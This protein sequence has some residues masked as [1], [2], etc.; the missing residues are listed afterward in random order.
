MDPKGVRLLLGLL[1]LW[2]L[3]IDL[4]LMIQHFTWTSLLAA[5]SAHPLAVAVLIVLPLICR[6]SLR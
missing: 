3:R 5:I 4:Q 2:D 6:R 1:A